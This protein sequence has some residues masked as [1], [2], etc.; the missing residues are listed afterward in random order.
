VI[1]G[2]LFL[3][4]TFNEGQ[5]TPF[6]RTIDF[7]FHSWIVM[8]TVAAVIWLARRQ[9]FG[10]LPSLIRL[11]SGLLLALFALVSML[12]FSL[13]PPLWQLLKPFGIGPTDGQAVAAMGVFLV[14]GTA[15]AAIAV[16]GACRWFRGRYEHLGVAVGFGPLYFYF[17]RRRAS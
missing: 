5:Q 10:R 16:R 2:A 1:L 11:F 14:W 17:R 7:L 6:Q 12:D 3:T 13:W 4:L 9:I 8:S 15:I